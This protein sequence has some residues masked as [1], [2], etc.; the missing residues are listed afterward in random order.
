MLFVLLAR[1]ARTAVVF[2]RGPSKQVALLRWHLDGD[3]F[4]VGQW[5]KGRIYERRCDLSP[6]GERL[7]YFAA[8]W[9]KPYETWT[10]IS[11]PPYLTALALWPKGNAWGGGGLFLD[12]KTIALN[13]Y[14]EMTLAKGSLPRQVRVVQFEGRGGGEDY[15]IYGVRL[16]RDGWRLAQEGGVHRAGGEYEW[17]LDPPLIYERR[18]PRGDGLL[19]MI[20]RG[21]GNKNGPWYALDHEVVGR[22]SLPSTSWADWDDNGDL[23]WAK[24]GV[25]HRNQRRLID[26]SPLKFEARESPPSARRWY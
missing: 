4:D 8:S 3:R 23:L 25:L 17:E 20:V 14:T 6:D 1:R 19:R 26:L 2:R 16:T 22:H 12:D 15:P 24:D 18:S 11:R 13:H 9:K 21:I 7:I 5:L 10:A